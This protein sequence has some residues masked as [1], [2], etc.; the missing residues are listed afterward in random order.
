[1][2]MKGIWNYF[3]QTEAIRTTK[4]RPNMSG[5]IK[6][7]KPRKKGDQSVEIRV[8]GQLDLSNI[9]EVAQKTKGLFSKH[10]PVRLILEEMKDLDLSGLQLIEAMRREARETGARF[11]YEA[12]PTPESRE[13]LERSGFG[14]MIKEGTEPE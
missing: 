8:K 14:H 3:E 5:A 7:K 4:Q 11:S 1:M 9:E 13:L 12:T 2:G 10:D 6:L